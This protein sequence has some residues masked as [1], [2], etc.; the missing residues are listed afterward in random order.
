[1]S[2][3]IKN[4]IT[5]LKLPQICINHAKTF[6]NLFSNIT[7]NEQR[8]ICHIGPNKTPPPPNLSAY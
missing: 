5:K 2:N 6:P 8:Q 1:M 7:Y 3:F 4:N